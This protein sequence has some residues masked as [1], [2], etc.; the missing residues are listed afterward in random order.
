MLAM[1]CT[2]AQAQDDPKA[3]Q[4]QAQALAAEQKLEAAQKAQLEAEVKRLNTRIE[5]LQQNLAEKQRRVDE[6]EGRVAALQAERAAKAD[7]VQALQASLTTE[8]RAFY[9]AG[10]EARL[11]LAGQQ[12]G[13]RMVE[14]LRFL[15]QARRT[16][17]DELKVEQKRLASAERR[18]QKERDDLTRDL[19]ALNEEQRRLAETT[20]RQ[21]AML[22]KLDRSLDTRAKRQAALEADRARLNEVLNNIK[23]SAVAGQ[24]FAKSKGKLDWPTQG[25]VLRGFGQTRSGGQGSWTGMVIAAEPGAEVRS[26]Q[27]GTVA[28]AGWLLGYGLLLVVEHD[29]GY[30]TLYGHNQTLEKERGDRV[31]AGEL[32]GRAGATGSLAQSGVFFGVN[33]EGRPLDPVS[34]LKKRG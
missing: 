33:R 9:K 34:W 19:T 1:F 21:S 28:Y 32:I 31:A 2:L 25:R 18:L 10:P 27:D 7:D 23:A 3:L 15:T 5:R 30:A 26:V 12:S 8:L 20:N 17:L 22:S 16:R 11:D 14:Y 6:Q 4:A 29:N 13:P 24:P